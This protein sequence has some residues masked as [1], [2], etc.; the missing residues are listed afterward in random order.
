MYKVS[1]VIPIY[2][3]E[4]Y[5]RQCLG[6]LAFQTLRDI[7]VICIDD[8]SEDGSREI[9]E[10]YAAKESCVRI[11]RLPENLGQGTARNRGLEIAHGEYVYFMDADDELANQDV[12]FRLVQEIDRDNLDVLFFDAETVI[13]DGVCNVVVRA[14]DYIRKNDYSVVSSGQELLSEFLKNREYT[15]SPCLAIYRR[16]FL[17]EN[18]IRFPSDHIFYEDNIFMTRVMLAAKR[19]SHRPWHL[20]VRKVHAGSTVMSKPTIRHLRGHLACYRDVC[21]LLEH[22]DWDRLTRKVLN[23]RRVV[24]K[25]NVRRTVDSYP[26]LL[27]STNDELNKDELVLLHAIMKYP[28]SEKIVNGLRCLRNHGIVYTLKRVLFGRQC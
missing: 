19:A 27:D 7:E 5:L 18:N 13:D 28:I 8:C 4:R 12:L 9:L 6:S 15:V 20:Y 26:D 14:E 2:N 21:E 16:S 25:L 23:D 22:S 11:L 1:I 24:Y 3:A 10:G 17:E